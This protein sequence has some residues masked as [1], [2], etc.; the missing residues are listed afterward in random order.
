M[1]LRRRGPGKTSKNHLLC[2][3]SGGCDGSQKR[4]NIE[5]RAKT[6]IIGVI[7]VF[8]MVLGSSHTQ[9]DTPETIFLPMISHI[10]MVLDS[11]RRASVQCRTILLLG[12]GLGAMVPGSSQSQAGMP[13]TILLPRIRLIEM[14]PESTRRASEQCRTILLVG[15]DSGA[16]V[17]G[18]SAMV[19]Y[20]RD[21]RNQACL[22]MPDGFV[23][24][25]NY[26]DRLLQADHP[27]M[28]GSRLGKHPIAHR[29]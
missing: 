12:K 16:M 29:F 14:V 24:L 3:K 13:E 20:H 23:L 25:A 26:Y 7:N 8:K 19:S 1:V 9:A 21:H 2:Q 6:I 11:L 5:K 22:P 4:L 28:S 10:E 17:I 15:K 18:S 27:H